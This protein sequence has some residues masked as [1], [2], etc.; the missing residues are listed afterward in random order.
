MGSGEG[1]RLALAAHPS[2]LAAAAAARRPV[3]APPLRPRAGATVRRALHRCAGGAPVRAGA[4]RPAPRRLLATRAGPDLMHRLLVIIPAL[5]EADSIA[6]V[7]RDARG[8]LDADVVVVDDGSVDAT[9]DLAVAAGATVLT[10]PYNL[11]VGGAIRTALRYASTRG[12]E[13]VLQLD[14]DGQHEAE[15]GRRLVEALDASG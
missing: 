11:G 7:V 8:V 9:G 3:L 12:Y 10:M 6:A 13:R 5:N 1:R 2:G 4:G 15:E 14:G